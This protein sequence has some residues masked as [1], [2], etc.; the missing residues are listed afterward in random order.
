LSPKPRAVGSN[1]TAPAKKEKSRFYGS[2]SFS[3]VQMGEFTVRGACRG[4]R[5]FGGDLYEAEAPTEL[6]SENESFCP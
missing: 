5:V 6:T 2:F 4:V 1:P 3:F